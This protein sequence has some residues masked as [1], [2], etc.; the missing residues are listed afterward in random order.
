MRPGL[1]DLVVLDLT[2]NY[3]G[4]YCTM[5]LADLGANVIH[6][7]NSTKPPRNPPPHFD[8]HG[9]KISGLITILKRN[10]KSIGLDL[11]NPAALDVFYKLVKTADVII[12]SY[13]PGIPTKLK[14]DYETVSKIN[15]GIIYLSLTGY[16]QDGPL[17]TNPGHDLNFQALAGILDQNTPKTA[18]DKNKPLINSSLQIGLFATGLLCSTA[19]LAA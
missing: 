12:E 4:P 3:P 17:A 5:N 14:I 2:H 9:T 7:E 8:I 13:R 18:P 1:Q 19:I 6:I 16:G 11:K 10:K 15:P